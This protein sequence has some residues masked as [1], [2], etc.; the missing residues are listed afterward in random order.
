MF[1]HEIICEEGTNGVEEDHI[2]NKEELMLSKKPRAAFAG[3]AKL[4]KTLKPKKKGPI[5]HGKSKVCKTG[6]SILGIQP[7]TSS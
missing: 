5:N 6:S 7:S 3:V 1:E 4:M 2:Y